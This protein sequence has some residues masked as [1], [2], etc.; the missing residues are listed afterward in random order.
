MGEKFDIGYVFTFFP[1]LAGTLQTTLIIVGGALLTSLIVGFL[2]AL[3]RLYK[4]PVLQ[5]LSQ[6]YASFFRGTPILIQLFLFYYGLPEILKLVNIDVSRAP[7]LV[8]VILTY[9]LHTGAYVSETIRSAVA[10]VDRGQVEAAYSVGMSGYQAF[11]RIVMPQ[12][13]AIA[14]PV[15][16]NVILALLK[17]TSLAFSLGVMEMTG[18]SQTLAALTNH[19]VESYI[20]LALIYLVISMVLER[21]LIILERRLLRHESRA[22]DPFPVF[23]RERFRRIRQWFTRERSVR[24]R[25]EAQ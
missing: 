15:L 23:R 10:S 18:K 3:P 14:V 22:A 8:F 24:L 6:L 4:V 11:T 25:E 13:L 16:S 12:A 21:L 7:V 20:S 1:K 5:R 17:D 2:V 9:G 19:F